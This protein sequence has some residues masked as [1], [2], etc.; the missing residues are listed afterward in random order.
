MLRAYVRW[1]IDGCVDLGGR[2]CRFYFWS[3]CRF[4]RVWRC[5]EL[6]CVAGV[7]R[8]VPAV[9]VINKMFRIPVRLSD[10]VDLNRIRCT[11]D[12][13]ELRSVCSWISGR[14]SVQCTDRCV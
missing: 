2:C 7:R 3:F 5:D 1:S 10:R 4:W 8:L 9:S 12:Y 13:G 14:N 6:C 11:H